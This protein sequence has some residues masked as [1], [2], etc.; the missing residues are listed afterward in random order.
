[1]ARRKKVREVDGQMCLSN[2]CTDASNYVVQ[3]NSLIDGRQSLKLNNAKLI[4]SAIIQ[5]VRNDEPYIITIKEFAQLLQI[6]ESNVY[7][8]ANDITDIS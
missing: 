3:A 2:F 7:S 1:M 4:R 5:I 6:A 8:F